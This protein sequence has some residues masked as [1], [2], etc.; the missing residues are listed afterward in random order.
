VDAAAGQLPGISAACSAAGCVPRHS[1]HDLRFGRRPF[2][3]RT[4]VTGLRPLTRGRGTECR[5]RVVL[6]A[7][8]VDDR[9]LPRD[10][11]TAVEV[12]SERARGHRSALNL[13]YVEPHPPYP[14]PFWMC[15]S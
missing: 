4:E 2:V 11:Y 13:A 5:R 7:C 3:A 12:H 10:H 6:D 15:S 14:Q 8:Q 1:G 9:S